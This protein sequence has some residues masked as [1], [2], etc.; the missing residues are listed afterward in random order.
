MLLRDTTCRLVCRKR[1]ILKY[2]WIYYIWGIFQP[3]CPL[4]MDDELVLLQ[5][6]QHGQPTYSVTWMNTTLCKLNN[7]SFMYDGLK[8]AKHCL[9]GWVLRI[10]SIRLW[11]RY[12][13]VYKQTNLNWRVRA[14]HAPHIPH[15]TVFSASVAMRC[16]TNSDYCGLANDGLCFTKC[17]LNKKLSAASFSLCV[18]LIIQGA[19]LLNKIH[20][21]I[22]KYSLTWL[23]IGWRLCCQPIRFQVWKSMLTD[24][25]F[26]MEIS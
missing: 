5:D 13:H 1:V 21:E 26:N 8:T 6:F 2:I 10:Q 3:S 17:R 23:L 18:M 20:I 14:T 7:N 22:N 15:R 19:G 9:I 16:K 11:V 24:M 25:Y 12:G 4:R